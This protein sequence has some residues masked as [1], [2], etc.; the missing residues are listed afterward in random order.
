MVLSRI[1]SSIILLA[2]PSPQWGDVVLKSCVL[3]TFYASLCLAKVVALSVGLN[4]VQT[5][6]SIDLS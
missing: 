2:T 5:A 1:F 4:D 3:R 6:V